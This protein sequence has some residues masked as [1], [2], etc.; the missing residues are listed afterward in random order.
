[1]L[2]TLAALV[3]IL[4]GAFA[5]Q[6]TAPRPKMSKGPRALGLVQLAPSGKAHL[7]PVVIMYNGEFYDASAYKASPVPMALEAGTVYEGIR[8]GVSQ[9]LFTVTGAL[10]SENDNTWAG[11]GTWQSAE[12]I[13][14]AAAAAEKR[15]TSDAAKKREEDEAK[16]PV[17]R[18]GG[19][20]KAP[21]SAPAP[22]PSASKP[23][24]DPTPPSKPAPSAPPVPTSPAPA[25]GTP[26][27]DPN[28]PVLRRGKPQPEQAS[29][30]PV[31]APSKA[32]S[33]KPAAPA[34][35][36][37]EA[38]SGLQFIPAISDVDGPEPRP[39]AYSMKPDEE[40]QF[41]KKA[42]AMA[43][44]ELLAREK[45]L[46][47]NTVGAAPPAPGKR[48]TRGTIAKAQPT[49]TDV[50]LRV[51]DLS[52]SNEPV[53]VL[54]ANAQL[55][56]GAPSKGSASLPQSIT[57]V[58][59]NDIYGELHKA[60]SSITDALHLDVTPRLEFI[61]AVDADGDGRGELLFRQATD[62]AHAFSLYR[63]IGNQLWPLFQGTLG[64]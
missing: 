54:M 47:S 55:T 39:Y 28:R 33:S 19:A 17:L 25:D 56:S 18:R 40:E 58:A 29:S 6:T 14:A 22:A 15:K 35:T 5:A 13:A 37:A 52:N 62:T 64:R 16:P 61:D 12:A 48:A 24:P 57:L 21:G 42:L 20:T 26:P 53:L 46:F 10:H 2:V 41:R 44:T 63:V 49:F 38:S 3:L 32:V 31:E 4:S 1:M 7:V 23:S 36:R 27:D 43:A 11:Q 51:L 60:F 30:K 8:T 9:G 45:Q 34:P 59:R 50:Q